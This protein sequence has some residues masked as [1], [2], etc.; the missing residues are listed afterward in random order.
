M[1][2]V[3]VIKRLLLGGFAV[4]VLLTIERIFYATS[5]YYPTFFTHKISFIDISPEVALPSDVL[6][7]NQGAEFITKSNATFV[8][9]GFFIYSGMYEIVD[10]DEY[11]QKYAN[12]F[13]FNR[14]Q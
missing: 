14:N 6:C 13:L 4:C 8:R 7:P 12:T 5:S 11:K 9:C 3:K 10:Y 2:L 1:A